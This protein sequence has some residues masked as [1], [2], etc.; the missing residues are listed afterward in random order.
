MEIR[1][2]VEVRPPTVL[3][4]IRANV[5]L[6]MNI[7]HPILTVEARKFWRRASAWLRWSRP[8][9]TRYRIDSSLRY[10]LERKLRRKLKRLDSMGGLTE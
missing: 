6:A 8:D 4:P 3:V 7:W 2:D 10:H 1:A 5:G 9:Y